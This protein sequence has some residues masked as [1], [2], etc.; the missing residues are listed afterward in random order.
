M[1]EKTSQTAQPKEAMLSVVI[2]LF[3]EG[4]NIRKLG[5]QLLSWEKELN[6]V[7]VEYVFVDDGSADDSLA[8]AIEIARQHSYASVIRLARN[9]GSHAAIA[10][11]CSYAQ[12]DCVVFIAGDLQDPPSL[13]SKM[14]EQWQAGYKIVW[15]A[16]T[17][18]E[19][20]APLNALLSFCYWSLFNLL[21]EYRVPLGGVDFALI[22]RLVVQTFSKHSHSSKPIFSRIADTGFPC[23]VVQY[24]KNPRA[25]GKSGWTWKKRFALVFQTV[26]NS[27]VPIRVLSLIGI[28]SCLV[29][30]FFCYLTKSCTEVWI[31]QFAQSGVTVSMYLWA[32]S[33]MAI[34]W[35]F[36]EHMNSRLKSIEAWPSFIVQQVFSSKDE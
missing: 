19:G 3:N 13:I 9:Y 20:Q 10:A 33:M 8:F 29:S 28:F 15:A 18:V 1:F 27:M 16:R 34:L 12:G 22:D 4:S 7:T 32:L 23:A 21:S 2:P 11:G 35:L 30:I 5:E 25:F 26:F 14:L 36:V 17:Q 31:C 24:T 6:N